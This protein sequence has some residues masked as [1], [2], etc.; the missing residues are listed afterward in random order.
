[1]RDFYYVSPK[2]LVGRKG[3][4]SL[5]LTLKALRFKFFF[6]KKSTLIYKFVSLN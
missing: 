6:L 4:V 1:V 3:I 2:M 5:Q